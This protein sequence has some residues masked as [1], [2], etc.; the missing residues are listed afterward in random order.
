MARRLSSMFGGAAAYP[1]DP[2]FEESGWRWSV[3]DGQ[4]SIVNC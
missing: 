2:G 4:Q 3:L 1:V